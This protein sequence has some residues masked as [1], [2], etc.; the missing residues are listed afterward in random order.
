MMQCC[1]CGR[2]LVAISITVLRCITFVKFQGVQAWSISS[3]FATNKCF[4]KISL[5]DL[6]S[7]TPRLKHTRLHPRHPLKVKVPLL[8]AQQSD[9][10]SKITNDSKERESKMTQNE[11]KIVCSEQGWSI[12][13]DMIHSEEDLRHGL[14]HLLR[15]GLAGHETLTLYRNIRSKYATDERDKNTVE[16][17]LRGVEHFRTIES[18]ILAAY[19]SSVCELGTTRQCS[20]LYVSINP[21]HVS[22]GLKLTFSN[23]IRWVEYKSGLTT[24]KV[25][26]GDK[27]EYAGR[28][29]KAFNMNILKSQSSHWFDMIDVDD[30]DP[31]TWLR[32]VRD[33][34]NGSSGSVDAIELIIETKNGYHVVYKPSKMTR[35]S[36]MAL[37]EVLSANPGKGPE[38][39]VQKCSGGSV[40]CALP[41]GCQSDHKTRIIYCSCHKENGKRLSRSHDG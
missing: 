12:C 33:A 7:C 32:R 27:E 22:E 21:R 16:D 13:M 5:H 25:K 39:K 3:H 37:K 19:R 30:K 40:S 17:G 11:S 28:L 9:L 2:V 31:E 34:I 23:F 18:G 38:S 36:H 41:G 20:A 35:E 15:N 24:Q 10:P 14:E 4:G 8:A 1:C 29:D 26:G 6:Q